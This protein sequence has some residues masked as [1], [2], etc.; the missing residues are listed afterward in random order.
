MQCH[1]GA[2]S[3][4]GNPPCGTYTSTSWATRAPGESASGGGH[5][6]VPA[7]VGDEQPDYPALPW[8]SPAH[9]SARP[10]SEPP[11]TCCS[12]PQDVEQTASYNPSSKPQSQAAIRAPLPLL[13]D[14]SP[15]SL[16]TPNSGIFVQCSRQ[17]GSKHSWPLWHT[18]LQ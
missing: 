14:P 12:P 8:P 2:V 9:D 3:S 4:T 17:G 1:A 16:P 18:Q 11:D 13:S 15:T 7:K 10:L 6:V 5:E